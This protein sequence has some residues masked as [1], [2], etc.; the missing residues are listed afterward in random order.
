MY[1]ELTPF[2]PGIRME[3]MRLYDKPDGY[4]KR[5]PYL[6]ALVVRWDSDTEV[7]LCLALSVFGEIDRRIWR[8]AM[9]ALKERGVAKVTMDRHGEIKT[10][11]T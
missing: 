2:E 1:I 4:K 7:F 8:L 5:L 6:A 3:V 9:R 11:P 10:Y